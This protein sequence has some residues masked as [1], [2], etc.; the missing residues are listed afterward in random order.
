MQAAAIQI[1]D[2]DV[3][4]EDSTKASIRYGTFA[5]TADGRGYR[6]GVNGAATLAAGKVVTNSAFDSNVE[7]MTVAATYTVTAG[8]NTRQI[9]VDAGGAVTANDYT[10]GY[11]TIVDATG[12]GGN[13]LVDGNTS[14]SG[15][16]EMTVTLAERLNQT[17]TVDVSIATLI[18]SP[19][20]GVI[21]VPATDQ[22]DF[23]AGI[24]NIDVTASYNCWLQ[25]K[26]VC[27]VW[28]DETFARGAPLTFGTGTAG[29]VE[30]VDAAG[31]VQFG[32]AIEAATGADDYPS[33]LLQID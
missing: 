23:P 12:E 14:T 1:T 4:T 16:A 32:V 18:K 24:P 33:V 21:I 6:Y 9:V 25:T 27:S 3:R 22:A 29:Q 2:Q 20:D 11:L 31:E 28:A 30:A 10:D 5:Q 26:G 19:W 13:Y 8:T 17:L 7:D 15:A